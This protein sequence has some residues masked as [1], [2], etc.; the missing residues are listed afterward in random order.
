MLQQDMG[1]HPPLR[2]LHSQMP[3]DTDRLF[4]HR[5]S[6]MQ[7]PPVPL[8]AS[9]PSSPH[10]RLPTTQPT[11]LSPAVKPS[12]RQPASN[13]H[14][15]THHP[16]GQNYGSLGFRANSSTLYINHY[17]FASPGVPTTH[18]ND[19]RNAQFPCDRGIAYP[20]GD[21]CE[22]LPRDLTDYLEKYQHEN[23]LHIGINGLRIRSGQYVYPF[24]S[25]L[26]RELYIRRG[27]FPS[28]FARH[29]ATF[30]K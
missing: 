18:R 2:E 11:V 16:I 29:W 23:Y 10:T 30:T 20:R 5:T 24:C 22:K 15:V 1:S 7:A 6:S 4:S 3:T 25:E 26:D 19:G 12:C 27:P 21:W 28:H 9:T 8:A 14:P 17:D 13:N